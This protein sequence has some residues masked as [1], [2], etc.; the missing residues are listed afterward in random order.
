M[1]TIQ[2]AE[3][4]L[5]RYVPNQPLKSR[6]TLTTMRALLASLGDPQETLRVVHVA[7]TSGKTST[8]YFIRG[9]CQAA[10]LRTGLTVSPHITSVTERVQING[11]P[12]PDDTFVTYL[13][14]FLPL[15]T[16]TDLRPTYFELLV[17]FAFWVFA[18]ERVDIAVVETGLGG[19]L[20][21]TNT[22]RR[23]DKLC[24]ITDIGLDHTEILGE[25]IAEI[26]RQKAG[27]I[28][29]GNQVVVQAQTPE[30]MTILRHVAT[31]QRAQLHIAHPQAHPL[32]PPFQQRNWGIALVAYSLLK[33]PPLTPLQRD[34]VA[35]LTPPGRL[36]RYHIAGK[37]VL[38]DGAHNSQKLEA[39]AH[40]LQ[41]RGITRTAVLANF[42]EAPDTKITAALQ[43][44]TTFAS[45][46]I[47]P[48]FTVAQ[49]FYNR[50]ALPAANLA[51]RL[52]ALGVTCTP[53]PN[54]RRALAAL[55][56]R[57]EQTVVI[58]GSLY[59]VAALR[60]YLSHGA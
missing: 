51:A 6:Y 11:A 22:V 37:T 28:Q 47:I 52:R 55:L 26:A 27:I 30:V 16:K 17:A 60:P 53:E 7:G 36:E 14:E 56:A 34:A 20:D 21:A 3:H 49:D 23:P 15:V 19:L 25:T 45:H 42:M 44:L 1:N 58:T 41:A 57:P 29:P 32:L 2:E 18:K 54:V 50:Q 9:L 46:V 5:L 12:L 39:L 4:A 24:V 13:R 48:E 40:A 35:A 10:G 59:L 33:L 38:L 31:H 8:A 43:T